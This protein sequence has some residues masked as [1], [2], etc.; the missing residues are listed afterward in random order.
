MQNTPWTH[1]PVSTPADADDAA[2]IPVHSACARRGGSNKTS[3][4]HLQNM[5]SMMY[6]VLF[7]MKI[8]LSPVP[9]S[10]EPSASY[11][12]LPGGT[13]GGDGGVGPHDPPDAFR[14]TSVH[15][16]GTTT[17]GKWGVFLR[18]GDHQ[19]PNLP[20][21]SHPHTATPTH[22]HSHTHTYTTHTNPITPSPAF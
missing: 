13:G 2:G 19:T 11:G 17:V 15:L 20:R 18:E 16:L 8:E 5:L 14:W 21:A 22:T 3:R 10:K 6:N 1:V 4:K 9:T 12:N 7:I